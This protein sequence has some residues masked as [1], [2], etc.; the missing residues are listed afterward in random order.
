MIK[1]FRHIRRSLINQNQMGKYLK[2][3]I[4]EIVLV[5]IGILIALQINN[6]NES[7]KQTNELKEIHQR[8]LLDIDNDIREINSALIFWK[9]KEPVFEKVMNDSMSADLFDVGLSRLLTVLPRT[10]LNTTGIQQLKNLNVKDEL[11]LR[12]INMYD[13][14]E[15]VGVLRLEK[16]IGEQSK[17]LRSIFQDKYEWFPEYIS[18]TIMK[19]NSSEELQNYFL[20]SMEY[21]NRVAGG[22]NRVFNNYIPNL[23]F[24]ISGLE[25]TRTDLKIAVAPNF[26][27]IS[28]KELEQYEG[29]YRVTKAEGDSASLED[30]ARFSVV[31]HDNFLRI[32]PTKSPR[33]F[34]DVFYN[35]K[36]SFI[37]EVDGVKAS[38]EF[39]VNSAQAISGFK[40][41]AK[42]INQTIY[43]TM[44]NE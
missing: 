43:A 19:D 12:I 32:F 4:G 14:M 9:E 21:K 10:N 34:I 39:S 31:A 29:S 15:N 24:Y 41:E 26:L 23:E 16:E 6:W 17:Q 2:Y 1:F 37:S 40:F 7:R 3:A 30:D 13:Q 25:K 28:K 11:S 42:Q 5:V 22:Y 18:K 20:T 44:E 35:E 36:R 38:F 27:E 8:I 33:N